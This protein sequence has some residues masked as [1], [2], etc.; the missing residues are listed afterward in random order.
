MVKYS[1]SDDPHQSDPKPSDPEQSEPHHKKD[2]PDHLIDPALR[3]SN[4]RVH[5][6]L[7]VTHPDQFQVKD[8]ESVV[9]TTQADPKSMRQPPHMSSPFV[10]AAHSS[11]ARLFNVTTFDRHHR[12]YSTRLPSPPPIATMSNSPSPSVSADRSSNSTPHIRRTPPNL[13]QQ[14]QPMYPPS[15]DQRHHYAQRDP[16]THPPYSYPPQSFEPQQRYEHHPHSQHPDSHSQYHTQPYF[17]VPTMA[18]PQPPPPQ[19]RDNYGRQYPPINQAPV[20]IVHTDDAATKLTDGIRRRC[21]NCCTTVTS[22]WRRSNLSPGK[23]VRL[24]F[25]LS[26]FFF[27]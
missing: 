18:H 6:N 8:Q 23:V 11:D 7:I 27:H 15:Y 13:Q 24:L 20:T 4:V 12:T 17:N 3:D 16:I 10:S 19:M 26:I 14:Q 9:E 25:S 1:A 5:I 22:T 21:F 2:Q